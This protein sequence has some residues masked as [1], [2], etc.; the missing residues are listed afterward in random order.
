VH[1]PAT[2]LRVGMTIIHNNAPHRVM[3]VQHVTPGNWRGMVH[4]KLRNLKTGTQSQTRYRSV[5]TVER[6]EM[7]QHEMEFLYASGDEYVFMNTETFDQ[8]SLDAETLGDAVKYLLSNSKLQIEFFEGKPVGIDLPKT[9]D[10]KVTYTE[11]GLKGATATNSPKPATLETG[12]VVQVPL[13]VE[14]G[15]RIKVDTRSGE[16]LARA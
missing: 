7:E 13:F 12:L 3:E 8:T 14:P 15:E 9:V 6:A 1:V 4:A 16:Y 10:L 11:P 5:D 2:Q